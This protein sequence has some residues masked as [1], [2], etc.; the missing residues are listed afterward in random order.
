MNLP[1]R[2]WLISAN[3]RGL[4]Q[5]GHPPWAQVAAQL[6]FCTPRRSSASRDHTHRQVGTQASAVDLVQRTSLGRSA[7]STA[8]RCLSEGLGWLRWR[9][10]LEA[11]R[12]G[13]GNAR[14]GP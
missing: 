11:A 5:D 1:C 7:L 3:E 10:H 14:A 13:N 12:P 4:S 8:T 6:G 9:L 2:M